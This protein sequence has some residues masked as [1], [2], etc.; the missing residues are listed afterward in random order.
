M[1]MEIAKHVGIRIKQCRES[2]G[3]T[4]AQ[5]AQALG[6]SVETISN[7]ERGKVATSLHTLEQIALVL[8]VLVRDF[9]DDAEVAGTPADMSESAIKV[10]NAAE[11]LPEDDLEIV[12]G[13]IDVLGARRRKKG[14]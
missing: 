11:L 6:K 1:A 12:A 4:Q 2:R 9:F 7:F 5:L 3:L 14:E 13:V 8:H 10:R